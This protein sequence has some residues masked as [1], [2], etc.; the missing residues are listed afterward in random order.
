MRFE[1]QDECGGIPDSADDP[2]KAFAQRRHKDRTGLG[3]GLSIAR[4]AIRMHGG[5]IYFRNLPGKGCVFV[6]DVPLAGENT[7]VPQNV[8]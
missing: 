4:K 8:G 2:F 1:V 6:I 5:D 7:P 3:L